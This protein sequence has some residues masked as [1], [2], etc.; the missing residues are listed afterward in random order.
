[1]RPER[2][3]AGYR[4]YGPAELRRLVFLARM[5][6][7]GMAINDLTHYI[8]LVN[9]GESTVP[10]RRA[11]MLAQRERIQHEIRELTLALEITEYKIDSYGGAPTD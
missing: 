7:S 5:R 9:R 2:N 6:L 11:I 3:S 4:Q 8:G 1:M 10:E